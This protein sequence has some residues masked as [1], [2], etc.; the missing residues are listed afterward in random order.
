MSDATPADVIGLEIDTPQGVLR[1]G[2]RV[3]PKPMRLPELALSFMGFSSKLTDLAVAH[4]TR[5][6]KEISCRKGCGACCRQPVPLS[7]P[8]AWLIADLVAGL[9]EPRRAA[10][11]A[12]FAAADLAFAN[13]GIKAAIL[14]AIDTL[15]Q[16]KTL[17]LDYFR[18]QIPCPFLVDEGCSIHP[19]R[20]SI[21]REYLVTSP[22]SFCALPGSGP[23]ARV[24]VG[25][26]LSEAL[27]NL[28]STLLGRPPEVIPLVFALEWAEAHRADG[29]RTWDART[30]ITALA[31]ELGKR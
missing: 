2:L 12:A 20:P 11:R 28:T 1:A 29:E 16:M 14:G 22:A 10:T 25:V 9:P 21:C 18:M 26:R 3:P 15:D 4:E 5:E 6:G 17:A 31:T 30:L 24:P 13:A 19:Y 7:P 27:T 23:V 8:E